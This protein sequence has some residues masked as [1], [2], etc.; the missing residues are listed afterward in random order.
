MLEKLM[1]L[2]IT[3]T[4]VFPIHAQ[5]IVEYEPLDDVLLASDIRTLQNATLKLAPGVYELADQLRFDPDDN[6]IIEGA[7]SGF[8]PNATVLDFLIYSE[9]NEDARAL[10]VRGGVTIRNLTILNA[11]GR[12]MDLRTGLI[13]A[14]SEEPVIF[15][16]VWFINCQTVFKSTG[17]RTVGAPEAPMVVSHCV[18]AITKDYPATF[19]T[20]QSVINLRDTSYATFDHCDFFN[21]QELMHLVINDPAAAPNEGPNVVVAN[22]ILLGNNGS[23]GEELTDD[24]YI[25]AGKVRIENSV[26][27]D[28]EAAGALEKTGAGTLEIINSVAND[29]LYAQVTADSALA[30]LDFNLRNDSPAL[31]LGKDGLNAGSVAAR[32]AEVGSWALY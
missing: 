5:Q 1:I 2:L 7:G 25:D 8:G 31:G 14:P 11:G 26:L 9:R 19:G 29:P 18:A 6:L 3:Y 12:A 10:S 30:A 21:R 15:E 23:G 28:A 24:L 4:F 22:S 13:E 27:W 32:P 17:G 16:N 20:P